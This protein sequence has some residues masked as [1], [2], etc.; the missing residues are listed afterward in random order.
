MFQALEIE[1]K[2]LSY[3]QLLDKQ[4]R[5]LSQKSAEEYLSVYGA[6]KIDIPLPNIFYFTFYTLTDGFYLFLYFCCIL[7]VT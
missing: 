5:P 1:T 7:W 2:T 3:E 6:C 4:V